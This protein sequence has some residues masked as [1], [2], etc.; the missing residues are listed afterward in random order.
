MEELK[1]IC[2][3]NVKFVVVAFIAFGL[4]FLTGFTRAVIEKNVQSN[5]LKKSLLKLVLY[6]SLIILG[7]CAE[8]LFPA[9]KQFKIQ[10]VCIAIFANDGYSVYENGRD[11]F[12]LPIVKEFFEKLK[13]GNNNDNG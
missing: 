2:N 7:G 5:K 9:E 3:E 6:F 4:D 13:G 12:N 8:I 11:I 10:F 1:V